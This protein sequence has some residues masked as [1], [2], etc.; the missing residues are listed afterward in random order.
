MSAKTGTKKQQKET[1][2]SAVLEKAVIEEKTPE[3][4]VV[5]KETAISAVVEDPVILEKE[6]SDEEDK[7]SDIN[8]NEVIISFSEYIILI[9]ERIENTNNL[10]KALNS[11]QF[12]TKSQLKDLN[13]AEKQLQKASNQFAIAQSKVFFSMA[14]NSAPK[15]KKEIK[16]DLNGNKITEGKNPV[17]W[18]D[19]AKEIFELEPNEIYGSKFLQY[20]WK[21]IRN[22]PGAK[23]GPL[24]ITSNPG[25]TNR[26]FQNIKRVML[27]RGVSPDDK[28][29]T[30]IDNGVLANTDI[31]KFSKY[32]YHEKEKKTKAT[33]KVNA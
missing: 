32:C 31:T 14:A 21:V 17:E 11:I 16:L 8:E 30:L 2:T 15:A 20:I 19:F 27:E 24:I 33:K 4:E 10:I 26:L 1:T 13:N 23:K 12:L 6:D 9:K 5:L 22:D 25:P 18:Y 3:K 7:N 29:I 28:V